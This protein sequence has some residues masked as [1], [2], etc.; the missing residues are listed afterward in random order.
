MMLRFA[1]A[2][3]QFWYDFI[4]GDDWRGAAVVAVAL[5]ATAVCVHVASVNA[6]WLLPAA[7]IAALGWSLRRATAG[8]T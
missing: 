3:G 8:R 6:W 7:V 5:A 4:I 1:K 2:V